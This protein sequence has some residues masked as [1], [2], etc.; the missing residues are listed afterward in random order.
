MTSKI[1]LV[2]ETIIQTSIPHVKLLGLQH[3]SY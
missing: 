2:V 1:L 3:A